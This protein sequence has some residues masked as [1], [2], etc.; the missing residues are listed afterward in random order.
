LFFARKVVLVEGETERVILPY[1]AKKASKFDGEISVIDCGSKYNL[2]LYITL[3]NA[4]RIHYLVVHDEDPVPAVPNPLP[5]DWNENRYHDQQR[6]FALNATIAE[7]IRSDLGSV[8]VL[9]PNF[10]N[11]AGVPRRQGE[12]KGKPIAA[13]DH[14]EMT[15][16]E[17]IP[18]RILQIIDAVYV[19][20]IAAMVS[21]PESRTD[22]TNSAEP[23]R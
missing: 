6:T 4:F 21:E 23:Q 10:E 17:D 11:V 3:L 19:A 2:P 1:L 13:L 7:L 12:K 8:I 18:P 22:G 5:Q 9:S 16:L 14:F 15:G 20:S